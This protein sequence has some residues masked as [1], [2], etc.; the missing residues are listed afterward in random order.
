ME[1]KVLSSASS[2]RGVAYNQ[3][4]ATCSVG[5]NLTS[6]C[7]LRDSLCNHLANGPNEFLF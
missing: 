6:V 3:Y 7:E 4:N 5:D 2:I 1:G